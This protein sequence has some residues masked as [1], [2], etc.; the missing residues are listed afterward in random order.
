MLRL[1]YA[2][3]DNYIMIDII[4]SY[5][6]IIFNILW[7]HINHDMQ[8]SKYLKSF[9]WIFDVDAHVISDNP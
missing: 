7:Y 8:S 5:T 1:Q 3:N 2:G 9:H 4:W 6:N